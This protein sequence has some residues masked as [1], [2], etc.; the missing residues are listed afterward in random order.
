MS[1]CGHAVRHFPLVFRWVLAGR[2]D[3]FAAGRRL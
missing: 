1:G 2:G 3:R